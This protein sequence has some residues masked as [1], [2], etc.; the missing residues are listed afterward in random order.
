MA[1]TLVELTHY[2]EQGL[3]LHK[4]AREGANDTLRRLLQSGQHDVNAGSYDL[5]RP[6]HEASLHGHFQCVR[7]LLDYGAQVNIRNIDGATPLCD[8]SSKGN[9]DIVMLLLQ[10]GANVNLPLT[11]HSP[12]H[13]AA[14][15]NRWEC[16][17]VLLAHRANPNVSDCFYGTPLHI[18][19]VRGHLM[20]AEVLLRHGA[21]VNAT[22]I[23]TTPL[24]RASLQ[25]D[26]GMVRMLLEH[27]ADIYKEDN[28]GRTAY[29]L[30]E[31]SGENEKSLRKLLQSWEK[32]PKSLSHFC[33]LSIRN[34]MG[35]RGLHQ[36]QT[37]PSSVP[38]V[39]KDFLQF[40]PQKRL[41]V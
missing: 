14:L 12:L 11:L 40:R 1:L 37:L 22:Y 3:P 20:S 30:V 5:M 35:N 21:K 7:T 13:E 4:A 15:N 17:E 29:S 39:I 36:L 9:V 23:H 28:R 6:L 25:G 33:R 10:N 8:A 32:T 26:E 18:A 31:G 16:L 38:Q 27:G 41:I 19:A 2:A 24:H 34:A